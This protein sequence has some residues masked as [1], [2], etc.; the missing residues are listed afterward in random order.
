MD[1]ENGIAQIKT[2]KHEINPHH[3]VEAGQLRRSISTGTL[4]LVLGREDNWAMYCV[5]SESNTMHPWECNNVTPTSTER[6]LEIYTNPI[7]GN[8]NVEV[9]E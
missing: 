6:V 5:D 7:K 4:F 8:I 1:N 2:V 3:P 9:F